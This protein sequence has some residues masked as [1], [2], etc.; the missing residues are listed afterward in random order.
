MLVIDAFSTPMIILT[1]QLDTDIVFFFT[2]HYFF[3][4]AAPLFFVYINVSGLLGVALQ[5]SASGRY[6]MT[7]QKRHGKGSKLQRD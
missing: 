2:E 1:R 7:Q 6:G 4:S 3:L 5:L